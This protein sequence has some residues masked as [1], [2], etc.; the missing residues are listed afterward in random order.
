M[1]APD[2]IF[3]VSLIIVTLLYAV[4]T[5]FIWHTTKKTMYYQALVTIQMDYRSPRM[6]YAVNKLWRFYREDCGGDENIL[7][8]KYEESYL[9]EQSEIDE[10]DKQGQIKAKETTLDNQRRIVSHFYQHLAALYATGVLPPSIIFENWS[11]DTL[12]IIPCILLPMENELIDIINA[13][14]KKL[15]E[16]A[17]VRKKREKELPH[18]EEDS[19]LYELYKGSLSYPNMTDEKKR[20]IHDLDI[21]TASGVISGFI[22]AVAVLALVKDAPLWLGILAVIVV[23]VIM[24][25][26]VRVGVWYKYR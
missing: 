5:G 9:K 25:F 21:G 4:L 15:P 22:V 1:D 14:E 23:W 13:E 26:L 20:L 6:G 19:S 24:R 10:M 2:E 8:K 16:S 3:Y 17:C 18:L 11:K 12:V 7:A